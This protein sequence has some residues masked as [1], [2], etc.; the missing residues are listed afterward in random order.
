[1]FTTPYHWEQ[2]HSNNT[3]LQPTPLCGPKIVAFLKAG[4]SPPAFPI[5]QCGAAKRQTVGPQDYS[6]IAPKA[7]E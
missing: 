3:R 5:Y 7:V 6:F 4:N 1:V 2:V